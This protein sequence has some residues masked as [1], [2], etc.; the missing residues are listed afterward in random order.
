MAANRRKMEWV[1]PTFRSLE[2][3]CRGQFGSCL[4]LHA[5]TLQHLLPCPYPCAGAKK[6]ALVF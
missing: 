6:H 3:G 4:S 2:R 5:I 1:A